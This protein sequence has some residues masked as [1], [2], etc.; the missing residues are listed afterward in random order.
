MGCGDS[1]GPRRT[2][3]NWWDRYS[4]HGAICP[5]LREQRSNLGQECAHMRKR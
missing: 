3:L 1:A 5:G 2:N 4:P